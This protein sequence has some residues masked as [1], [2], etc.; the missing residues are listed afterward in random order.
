MNSNVLPSPTD[1]C[2]I[3]SPLFFEGL[4]E[5]GVGRTTIFFSIL[6]PTYAIMRRSYVAMLAIDQ[7]S[8]LPIRLP[9]FMLGERENKTTVISKVCLA[10]H[11]D[12]APNE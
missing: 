2:H 10:R 7:M 9:L 3:F 6:P 8:P 1:K 12:G 11:K 4:F 5:L